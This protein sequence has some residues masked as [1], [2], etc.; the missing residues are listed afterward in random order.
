[1]PSCSVPHLPAKGTQAEKGKAKYYRRYRRKV[2]FPYAK[3]VLIKLSTEQHER[4]PMSGRKGTNY[5]LVSGY[6]IMLFVR[7][8]IHLIS[9]LGFYNL[10]HFSMK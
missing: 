3:A 9:E 7:E 4:Q 1:M 10:T 6:C 8:N 5:L 2:N